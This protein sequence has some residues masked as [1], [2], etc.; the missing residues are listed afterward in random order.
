MRQ[1]ALLPT[2]NSPRK[3]R[4][5]W[6]RSHWVNTPS[7]A[8]P[9]VALAQL[10]LVPEELPSKYW[11]ASKATLLP[12]SVMASSAVLLGVPYQFCA[13][14]CA[15][16]QALPGTRMRFVAPVARMAAMAALAALTHC[17][18]GMS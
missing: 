7:W 3:P 6:V 15:P 5:P 9:A 2:A 12:G 10:L 4:L 18:V 16:L 11:C 17:S 8:A 13:Q 14:L 1:V